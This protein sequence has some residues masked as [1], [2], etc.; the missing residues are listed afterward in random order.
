MRETV[1]AKVNLF[2]H[3]TGRRDNGYHE[4]ESLAVF[5]GVGDMLSVEPDDALTLIASGPFASALPDHAQDNLVLRAAQ[6]LREALGMKAGAALRLEK[7]LPVASG[8]GGG[9][10]DAAAVLRLLP[11][12]WGAGTPLHVLRQVAASLGSD[13]WLCLH[14]QTAFVRGVGERVEL[15]A[16]PGPL[17]MVLANPGMPVLTADV[18]RRVRPPYRTAMGALPAWPSR[19]AFIA[20]LR[21]QTNDLQPHAIALVPG[22]AEVLRAFEAQPGCALAR[23]SGSG[24]TCFGLF[25]TPA[26]ADAAQ[27]ALARAGWWVVATEAGM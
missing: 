10:A 27:R 13:V 20:W 2:L 12:L 6:A 24:A 21:A 11:Q 9:S 1:R 17:H 7:N 16:L 18:Y 22:I 3:V 8:I 19:E 4:I 25:D 14:A 26:Q 5:A 23:M 15:A